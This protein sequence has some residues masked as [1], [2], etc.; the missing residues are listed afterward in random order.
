MSLLKRRPFST[1]LTVIV[2]GAGA[3]LFH[4]AVRNYALNTLHVQD[5]F[6]TP[7]EATTAPPAPQAMPV[8]VAKV[9]K[10]TLPVYLDYPARTEA[11]QSV[12][13]QAKVTGFLKTQNVADGAD[14]KA[15][16]VLYT[17]DDRDAQAALDQAKAQVQRD[18]AQIDYLRSNLGR[19][20]ELSQKGFLAKDTYDQRSSSLQQAEAA[21]G[22]SKAAE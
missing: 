16:D 3:S 5:F 4:P 12:S 20:Q 18:T 13:L 2:V 8:P 21:I 14:V 7:A 15:G 17:I 22:I 9:E 19:G 10:R 1:A 6:A 11:I